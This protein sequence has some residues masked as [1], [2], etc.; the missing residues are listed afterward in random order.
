MS[1]ESD[2]DGDKPVVAK[3]AI[4]CKWEA[5]AN[6][7]LV[8]VTGSY[9]LSVKAHVDGYLDDAQELLPFASTSELSESGKIIKQ[10]Q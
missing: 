2:T 8:E 5:G 7:P 10:K 9:K 6:N 3:L 4:T 1:A